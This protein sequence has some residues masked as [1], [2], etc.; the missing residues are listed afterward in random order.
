MQGI[1]GVNVVILP[2]NF[3]SHSQHK[4]C[5]KMSE[6][7]VFESQYTTFHLIKSNK[8]ISLQGS[9]VFH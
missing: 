6:V 9:Y 2:E 4:P 3:Y 7:F 8:R 5:K 1:L